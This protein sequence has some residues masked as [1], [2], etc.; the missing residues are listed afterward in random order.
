MPSW[1][2]KSLSV[3]AFKSLLQ[4]SLVA[5]GQTRGHTV[6]RGI[7]EFLHSLSLSLCVSNNYYACLKKLVSE[8]NWK[9]RKKSFYNM[10][11]NYAFQTKWV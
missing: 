1:E 11:S 6:D 5:S 3:C 8:K 4:P 10:R 7:P 2:R 9:S